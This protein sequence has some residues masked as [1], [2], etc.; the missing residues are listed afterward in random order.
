MPHIQLH[1]FKNF[2]LE[3]PSYVNQICFDVIFF[4]DFST[5]VSQKK[6]VFETE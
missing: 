5:Q 1:I 6:H 3:Q 2:V 4:P